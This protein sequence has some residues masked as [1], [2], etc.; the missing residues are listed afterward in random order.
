MNEGQTWELISPDLTYNNEN[1][2]GDIP[3][4]TIFTLSESPLKF[5]LLYAGTDDGRVWVTKNS[6]ADWQEIVSGL[7]YR[8]W[9]SQ[10]EASRFAEGRVYMTQNGKRDDDFAAYIWKSENYG[11]SWESIKANIPYGPVNVIREDP[12]NENI[13]YVGTDY[14]VFV[15]TNRGE[16][17]ETLVGNLP[18]TYVHDLQIQPRDEIAVIAT[19]GRGVWALDVRL[20]YQVAKA[21]AGTEAIEIL[22]IPEV[23]APGRRYYMR[24]SGVRAPFFLKKAGDVEWII[25]N[26]DGN[27]VHREK[28]PAEKGLNYADWNLTDEN[29]EAVEAGEYVLKII[30]KGK[31]AE[32]DFSVKSLRN[33]F[34]NP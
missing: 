8:K 11:Q 33:T 21:S 16:S 34:Y 25:T 9:V 5:G 27:V 20:L 2:K 14:G 12:K 4:Q 24:S 30:V 10:I 26:A 15:S 28:M 6:G 31:E 7:P 3:Y 19:H 22:D 1:M 17:W 29:E 23:Y 18:T 13:L 32:K